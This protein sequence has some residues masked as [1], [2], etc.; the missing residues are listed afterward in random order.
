MTIKLL[1][2]TAIM[3]EYQ[4]GRKKATKIFNSAKSLDRDEWELRPTQVPSNLVDQVYL[5]TKKATRQS[6]IPKSTP[7]LYQKRS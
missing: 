6:G 5:G 1:T 2:I 4:V 7:T 3:R